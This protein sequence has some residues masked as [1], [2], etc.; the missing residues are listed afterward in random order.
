MKKTL[1]LLTLLLFLMPYIV[2]AEENTMIYI[3]YPQVNEEKENTLKIQGWYL[4]KESNTQLEI[5]VDDEKQEGIERVERKGIFDIIK[6]YGD[7][8]TNEKPGY[9][10]EIN[11][12][13]YSYGNHR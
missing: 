6:D 5:Y 2:K 9:Y 13:N 3:D 1:L 7:S 8:S 4:T 10:K 11:I 12:E